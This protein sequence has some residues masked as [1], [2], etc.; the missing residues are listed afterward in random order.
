MKEEI[1]DK[2]VAAL[3]SGKYVQTRDRLKDYDNGFCC[4]GVLCDISGVSEWKVGVDSYVYLNKDGTLPLSVM[5]WAGLRSPDGE[6]S[7]QEHD[8]LAEIND[9]GNTFETISQIIEKH[10]KEL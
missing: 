7:G 6:V 10:W 9:A 5:E 2:W 8:S 3:R 1:K 4:L